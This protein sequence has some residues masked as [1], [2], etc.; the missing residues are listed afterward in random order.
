MFM[1]LREGK[2]SCNTHKKVHSRRHANT[3]QH[4]PG[5]LNRKRK[6]KKQRETNDKYDLL[7]PLFAWF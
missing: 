7:F 4:A 6:R 5:A 3:K 2:G 1:S